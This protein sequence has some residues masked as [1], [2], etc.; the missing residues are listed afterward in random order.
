M[1]ARWVIGEARCSTSLAR[2]EANKNKAGTS[3]SEESR[4]IFKSAGWYGDSALN[5]VGGDVAVVVSD[6]IRSIHIHRKQSSLLT[7]RI[8]T[9][10]LI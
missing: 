6:K 2:A 7:K 5:W 4:A 3:R 10:S 8:W 9:T 1:R